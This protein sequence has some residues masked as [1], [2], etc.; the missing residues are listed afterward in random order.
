MERVIR[1]ILHLIPLVPQR[2]FDAEKF[3]STSIRASNQQILQGNVPV[4][5]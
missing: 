2:L 5:S 1:F 3:Y 4:G